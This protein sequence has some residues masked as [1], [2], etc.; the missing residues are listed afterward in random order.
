MGTENTN[1]EEPLVMGG[2]LGQEG[3]TEE[4]TEVTQEVTEE[5]KEAPITIDGREFTD[6]AEAWKYAESLAQ[7]KAANDNYRQGVQDA[8]S[9]PNGQV[10]SPVTP[11]PDDFEEK[12]YAD[13]K[14]YLTERDDKIRKQ[15]KDEVTQEST[16]K[17]TV[18]RLWN[19][20]YNDNPD[21]VGKDRL[22]KSLLE[23]NWN[24]LGHMTDAPSAMKILAQKTRTEI[25][26]YIESS[27]PRT[28]LPN[29]AGGASGGSQ[30]QVTPK[31]TDEPV[32]SF[33][34][35]VNKLNE[36]RA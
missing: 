34:E 12:F 27:Q 18:D 16:Q 1:T 21:L 36:K 31:K 13:P 19:Q 33:I 11:E 10:A 2:P 20:F 9:Q 15:I 17:A 22:V 3:I 14:K 8:M 30:S 35:Q 23:E 28:E 5:I 7:D 24:T 4:T 26:S 25:Q 29:N 32:L 6:H